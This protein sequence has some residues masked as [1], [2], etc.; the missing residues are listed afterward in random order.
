MYVY[1]LVSGESEASFGLLGR[2]V[3]KV[4]EAA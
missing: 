1:V 3:C 4:V 2:L